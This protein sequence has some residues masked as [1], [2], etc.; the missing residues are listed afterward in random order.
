MRAIFVYMFDASN[1]PK[2]FVGSSSQRFPKRWK[3]QVSGSAMFRSIASEIE[4]KD[5]VG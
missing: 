2:K 4:G 5:K 3:G 1:V